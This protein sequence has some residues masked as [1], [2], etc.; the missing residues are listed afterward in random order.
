[1][2]FFKT[3]EPFKNFSKAHGI[4]SESHFKYISCFSASFS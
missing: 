3:A 1:L 2:L 4:L